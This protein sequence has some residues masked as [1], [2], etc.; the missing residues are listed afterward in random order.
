MHCLYSVI[1]LKVTDNGLAQQHLAMNSLN[2]TI[3]LDMRSSNSRSGDQDVS[4]KILTANTF[5]N[6]I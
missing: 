3:M 2:Y 5:R 4:E 1:G 6:I